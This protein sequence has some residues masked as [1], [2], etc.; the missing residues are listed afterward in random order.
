MLTAVTHTGPGT[1]QYFGGLLLGSAVGAAL[2]RRHLMVWKMFVSC[3]MLHA[4]ELLCV[5]DAVLVGLWF[6]DGRIVRSDRAFACQHQGRT[7]AVGL[8][9]G[10]NLRKW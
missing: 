3:S 9:E 2:L 1:L 6:G 10:N 4:I 5:D 7:R 8:S